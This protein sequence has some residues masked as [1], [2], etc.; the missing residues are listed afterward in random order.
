[1]KKDHFFINLFWVRRVVRMVLLGWVG[2][3]DHNP[4]AQLVSNPPDQLFRRNLPAQLF[5][6]RPLFSPVLFDH[7]LQIIFSILPSNFFCS[8]YHLFRI[9]QISRGL[10]HIFPILPCF[11]TVVFFLGLY[12]KFF[13]LIII[14]TQLKQNSLRRLRIQGLHKSRNQI[15]RIRLL[16]SLRNRS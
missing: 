2:K 10:Y 4:P 9:D 11:W 6:N 13:T 3:A 7:L 16:H 5:Q 14:S 15:F 1:M 8:L 12:R